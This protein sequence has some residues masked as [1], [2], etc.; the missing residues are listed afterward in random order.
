MSKPTKETSSSLVGILP[1]NR[2]NEGDDRKYLQ[3]IGGPW[4]Q[5]SGEQRSGIYDSVLRGT[6]RQQHSK[7]CTIDNALGAKDAKREGTRRFSLSRIANVTFYNR[8]SYVDNH[9]QT[10]AESIFA[11]VDCAT[12]RNCVTGRDN[13]LPLGTT[14]NRQGKIAGENAAGGNAEY[15]GMSESA[16]TKAFDL[17]VGR[18]GLSSQ[19]AI[20]EGFKPIEATKEEQTRAHYYPG[21]RPIWIKTV[22]DSKTR[23]LLG[24]QIVGAEAVKGRIDQIA[25][26]LL[27]EA[28]IDDIANY[29]SYYVPPASPV[30]DPLS[31]AARQAI[32]L[33]PK[34][35]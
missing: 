2:C 28:K 20:K 27:L 15:R 18:T 34:E 9:M 12:A 35:G 7:Y 21:S 17:Y 1:D 23:R 26:A 31:V 4:T 14:A 11:A 5:L 13:H 29:D 16:I 22:S 19:D 32:D 33:M 6:S 3:N 25:H 10:G 8:L 30:C 24:Y